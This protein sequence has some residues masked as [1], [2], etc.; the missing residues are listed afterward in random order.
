LTKRT[1]EEHI[2]ELIATKRKLTDMTIASGEQWVGALSNAEPKE[3]AIGARKTRERESRTRQPSEP[4]TG[5]NSIV[6]R[7][8]RPY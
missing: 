5:M 2:N 1:F 7:Q 6:P 4:S 8:Q 3:F